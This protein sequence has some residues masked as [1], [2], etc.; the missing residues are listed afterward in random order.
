MVVMVCLAL[1]GEELGYTTIDTG[2][3]Y[4]YYTLI[5]Y[6]EFKFGLPLPPSILSVDFITELCDYKTAM[7]PN[8]NNI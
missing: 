3:Y 1:H 5:I 8:N 6:C 2:L 7:T 4:R